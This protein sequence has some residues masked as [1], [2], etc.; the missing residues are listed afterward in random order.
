MYKPVVSVMLF[1]LF[2]VRVLAAEP[3]VP[4]DY[5]FKIEVLT[6]GLPQPM[7]L[8]LAPDGRIFFNE[9]VAS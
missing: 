3:S 1:A 7:E 4:P 2:A 9:S 5:R 8:E 6:A